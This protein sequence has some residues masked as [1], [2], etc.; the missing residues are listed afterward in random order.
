[1]LQRLADLQHRYSARFIV[2]AF[3]VTLGMLPF[4]TRLKLNSDFTAL[5]PQ[6]APSVRDL[7]RIKQRVKGLA[8]LTLAVHGG[9]I[10]DIRAFVRRLAPRLE[11]LE[12]EKVVGVDWNLA[13]MKKFVEDHKYLY[14]EL[15][16]LTH[17]RDLLD[18]RLQYEH[19][20]NNPLYV[21][22]S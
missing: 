4:I 12:A 18:E 16:D 8:T 15:A 11:K 13:D 14:A 2:A 20:H 9:Q 19:V 1:F 10:E 3:L 7:D 5:L 21:D 6:N 17:V 22:V